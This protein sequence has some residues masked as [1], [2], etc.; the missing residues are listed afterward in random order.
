MPPQFYCH[1]CGRNDSLHPIPD[2]RA[3][4]CSKCWDIIAYIASKWYEAGAKVL[5]DKEL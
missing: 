5:P 4:V 3:R 1:F 2:T